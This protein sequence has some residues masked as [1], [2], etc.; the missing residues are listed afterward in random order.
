MKKIFL[1]FIM[2]LFSLCGA[3]T[4][5]EDFNTSDTRHYYIKDKN[6]PIWQYPHKI[7]VYVED[8]NNKKG[9]VETACD[10]WAANTHKMI[11]FYFTDDKNS[12]DVIY[13]FV[14]SLPDNQAGVTMY[15]KIET[16]GGK[17]YLSL[18][19][20]N[21]ALKQSNGFYFSDNSLLSTLIHETGHVI[22]INYHSK[23]ID[24][25]MYSTD[26][27]HRRATISKRDVNTL[28]MIYYSK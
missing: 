9:L 17:N 7:K 25:V 10:I 5:N 22:G 23:S 3:Y 12:A 2:F 6:S 18:V 20:V 24:D 21:I 13:T 14:D 1:I 19:N 28:K 15:S 27:T 4:F 16:V 26:E 8:K 11:N